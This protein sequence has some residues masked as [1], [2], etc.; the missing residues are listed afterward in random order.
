M[1]M[2][3][4]AVDVT[5]VQP[6]SRV[7]DFLWFCLVAIIRIPL[8]VRHYPAQVG[9]QLA[10]VS[11]GGGGHS[12]GSAAARWGSCSWYVDADRY[13][14]RPRGIQWPRHLIGLAPA[15]VSVSALRCNTRE[16]A[17]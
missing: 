7:G 4:K 2:L 17:P 13:R 15:D 11:L 10:E 12:G 14:G 6:V 5:V 16:I 8:A 9:R 1:S 3:G